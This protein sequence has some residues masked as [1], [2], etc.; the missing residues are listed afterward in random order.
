MKHLDLT[1]L[2]EEDPDL[3]L[4][5]N[6]YTYIGKYPNLKVRLVHGDFVES[7]ILGHVPVEWSTNLK[8]ALEE[9]D[10]DVEVTILEGA[11]HDD[12]VDPGKEAF[13]VV[14]EQVVDLARNP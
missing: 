3:W 9:A 4:A 5:L 6:P 13:R 8:Q 12:V 2:E 14:V 10:Y 7:S 11:D 1:Y